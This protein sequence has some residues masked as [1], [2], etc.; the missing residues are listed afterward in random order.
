MDA[1][2]GGV[3]GG[4]GGGAAAAAAGDGET[5]QVDISVITRS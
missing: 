1:P 4:G 3:D 5:L 2:G